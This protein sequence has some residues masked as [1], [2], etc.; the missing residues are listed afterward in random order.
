MYLSLDFGEIND[1]GV[2]LKNQQ[3]YYNVYNFNYANSTFHQKD[4]FM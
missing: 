4:L 1:L 2:E 3:Q